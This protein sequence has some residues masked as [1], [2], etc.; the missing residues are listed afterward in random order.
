MEVIRFIGHI[1]KATIL[2][3][4][5]ASLRGTKYHNFHGMDIVILVVSNKRIFQALN[6]NSTI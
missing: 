3:N 6:P 2:K 5:G 4:V 1:T